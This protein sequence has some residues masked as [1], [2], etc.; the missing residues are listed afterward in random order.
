LRLVAVVD[1]CVDHNL[2][3]FLLYIDLHDVFTSGKISPEN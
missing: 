2:L 1:E 3:L